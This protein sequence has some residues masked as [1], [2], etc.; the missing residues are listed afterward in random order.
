[1]FN[2]E[3][4][5][6]HIKEDQQLRK[7]LVRLID[8]AEGVL[9]KHEVKT[10]D[11]LTPIQIKYGKQILSSIDNISFTITGG[12][13]NAE[14]CLICIYPDYLDISLI[15]P[16][17]AALELVGNCQ[18]SNIF[19][20]DYLGAILGLGLKREKIGDIL[21]HKGEAEKL[22]LCH[23]IVNTEIK[24]YIIYNLEKVGNMSVM[25]REISIDEIK[26]LQASFRE[27]SGSI[28]SLRLDAVVALVCKI[29]RGDAQALINRELVNVNWEVIN[30]T[31]YEVS[32]GDIISIRGKGRFYIDNI[33]GLTKSGRIA[34]QYKIPL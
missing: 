11:F 25:V 5:L 18:F 10:T 8:K 30:K 20:K 13:P 15:S 12:Y 1:M 29:S 22:Q 28:A 2:R 31:S 3:L 14:R 26:P 27:M 17:V 4:I 16:P 7:D 32:I 34:L 33:K 24:D 19:H 6:Q 23:I 9:K 21:L